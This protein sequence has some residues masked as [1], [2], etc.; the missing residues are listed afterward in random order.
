MM[1]LN[2]FCYAELT[3][4]NATRIIVLRI[5]IA[6]I[7]LDV[8]QL[9]ILTSL[10]ATEFAQFWY[11]YG[12]NVPKPRDS[13]NDPYELVS[14]YGLATDADR[15]MADPVF[16][17]FVAYF[18]DHEYA[19]KTISDALAGTTKWVTPSMQT[20]AIALT[21]ACQ[22]LFIQIVAKLNLAL[23]QCQAGGGDLLTKSTSLDQAAAMLIGSMEGSGLGGS[24]DYDDGQLVYTLANKRASQFNT[25]N[26]ANYA[27]VNSRI[28]DLLFASKAQL[29]ASDCNAFERSSNRIQKLMSIG[30]IQSAILAAIENDKLSSSSTEDSLAQ[31][32]IL[33]L[34]VLPLVA[35]KD[36]QTT[37]LLAENMVWKAGV[38]PVSDGAQKVSEGWGSVVAKT[39]ELPCDFLGTPNEVQPCRNF[40][41]SS[42]LHWQLMAW[43]SPGI[44]MVMSLMYII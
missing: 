24:L 20:E 21:C 9:R 25:M 14:L 29:D 3:T 1:A 31:G 4:H 44:A 28:E 22:I 35:T 13:E 40:P 36:P 27:D 38:D 39:L 26:S 11:L 19:D 12:S 10:Q 17:Q 15:Q 33:T 37:Q 6:R 32:E 42:A 7:D 41:A 2:D 23:S 8:Y 16:T 30:I 43:L 5:Q 34:S 18:N